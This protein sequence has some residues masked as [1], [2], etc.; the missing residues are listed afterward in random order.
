MASVYAETEV[1]PSAGYSLTARNAFIAGAEWWEKQSTWVLTSAEHPL[2]N[3]AIIG[4]Y[5]SGY[6]VLTMWYEDRQFYSNFE[7]DVECVVKEPE[8]WIYVPE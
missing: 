7:C 4:K 6:D 3:R 8:F 1:I 2:E 5:E